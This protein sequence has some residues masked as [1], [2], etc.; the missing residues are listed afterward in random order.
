M[1]KTCENTKI[2]DKKTAEYLAVPDILLTHNIT[3]VPRPHR[4]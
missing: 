3:C 1:N 4:L 2:V